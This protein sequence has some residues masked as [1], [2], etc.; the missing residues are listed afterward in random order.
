MNRGIHPAIDLH[1]STGR[2]IR[3]EIQW[4]EFPIGMQISFRM[5]E[6]TK[7]SDGKSEVAHYTDAL[8]GR[9]GDCTGRAEATERQTNV[10]NWYS[11][12]SWHLINNIINNVAA[13]TSLSSSPRLAKESMHAL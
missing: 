9:D 1:C 4:L 13:R 11:H 5:R 7:L 8:G 3:D 12:S 10:S 6:A 2:Q